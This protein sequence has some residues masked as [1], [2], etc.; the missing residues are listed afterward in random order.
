MKDFIV[1]EWMTTHP[2]TISSNLTIPEAYWKMVEKKIRRLLVVD[3]EILVGIVTIDDL[4]QK[5]PFTLYAI[6][7]MRAS[8]MLS[9]CPVS[10][11]MSVNPITIVP[12]ARLVEAAKLMLDKRISTL[13]VMVDDK[14]IGII[15][16][17][18]IFRAFVK[19][20]EKSSSS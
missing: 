9:H 20:A 1:S 8:D 5:I 18:D 7:S 13:P 10:K 2:V 3:E 11:V 17:S 4:R 6:D 14:V 19:M 12:D 16:E 15:T